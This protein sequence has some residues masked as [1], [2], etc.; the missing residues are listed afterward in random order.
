MPVRPAMPTD[1]PRVT[2]FLSG[3]SREPDAIVGSV[4]PQPLV[5]SALAG[6]WTLL[7]G[8]LGMRGRLRLFIEEYRGR[9]CAV[10]LV[11]HGRRPD[12]H[13]PSR[14]ARPSWSPSP[15]FRFRGPTS[16]C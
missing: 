11:Y 4:L 2:R 15:A 6:W 13:A 1:L 16:A 5:S 10:A 9:L 3:A 8:T 14:R 12:L 7:P